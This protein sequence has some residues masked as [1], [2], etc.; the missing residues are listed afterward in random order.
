MSKE[1]KS[2]GIALSRADIAKIDEKLSAESIKQ[3]VSSGASAPRLTINANGRWQTPDGAELDTSIRVVVVDFVS[4][5]MWYPHPYQK[6]N[7]LPPNCMAVGKVLAEM[8]P[9]EDSPEPQHETCRGCPMDEWGSS[10]TGAGKACKN[11][12]ELAVLLA[13]QAQDLEEAEMFIISIPPT[14]IKHFDGFARQCERL[15]NGPPIKAVVNIEAVPVPG[16]RYFSM[17]FNGLEPNEQYP[18]HFM[19]RDEAL[20]L[21]EVMPDTSNFVPANQRPGPARQGA[22]KR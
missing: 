9:H 7:P 5:N 2:T 14:S 19:L 13:D 16:T 3:Q 11:T 15:L 17:S 18:E 22:P 21:L 20:A 12:R 6:G 8:A 1:E 4:K 10:A